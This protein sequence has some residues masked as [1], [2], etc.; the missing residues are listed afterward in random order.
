MNIVCIIS[1]ALIIL[2]IEEV[3]A[4]HQQNEE[5][6]EFFPHDMKI[7]R[8]YNK[9]MHATESIGGANHPASSKLRVISH[10]K[11]SRSH[12]VCQDRSSSIQIEL[13]SYIDPSDLLDMCEE[14]PPTFV[15]FSRYQPYG[16]IQRTVQEEQTSFYQSIV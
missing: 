13:P 14:S 16:G 2:W 11:P 9:I 4:L 10:D 8:D 7:A 5:I 1:M 6:P 15:D 3:A 12:A